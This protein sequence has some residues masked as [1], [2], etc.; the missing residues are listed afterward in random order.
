MS[1]ALPA[2]P[3]PAGPSPS[4]LAEHEHLSWTRSIFPSEMSQ[5]RKK[6]HPDQHT[7]PQGLI[8]PIEAH[9]AV[10]PTRCQ[11]HREA[12]RSTQLCSGPK[13]L[14]SL[15]ARRGKVY[16]PDG[17]LLL[18]LLCSFPRGGK[19]WAVGRKSTRW[20]SYSKRQNLRARKYLCAAQGACSRGHNR[21][22]FS[23]PPSTPTPKK[24]PNQNPLVKEFKLSKIKQLL[25]ALGLS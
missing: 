23:L 12:T 5:D 11:T 9:K 22:S 10:T 7:I 17:H 2:W 1:P 15:G 4:F 16:S 19:A 21:G 3:Q 20:G 6:T 25:K 13:Q 8:V 24:Q 14:G 18:A